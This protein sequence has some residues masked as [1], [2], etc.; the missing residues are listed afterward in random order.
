LLLR[1]KG[2]A[3]DN[4]PVTGVLVRARSVSHRILA[5]YSVVAF[6]GTANVFN[7]SQTIAPLAPDPAPG[8]AGVVWWA[9]FD[10]HS[11]DRN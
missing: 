5:K 9:A 11:P 6:G 10:S 4:L 8:G 3:R 7:A 2:Q 1:P